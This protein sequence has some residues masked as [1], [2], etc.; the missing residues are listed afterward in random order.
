PGLGGRIGSRAPM[1]LMSGSGCSRRVHLWNGTQGFQSGNVLLACPWQRRPQPVILPD[2]SSLKPGGSMP[3][4]SNSLTSSQNSRTDVQQAL[5]TMFAN[6]ATALHPDYAA[7]I[8][9]LSDA[10]ALQAALARLDTEL[11]T[12]ANEQLRDNHGIN[13]PPSKAKLIKHLN[14]N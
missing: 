9:L 10:T 14:N 1:L 3:L 2:G 8:C 12:A 6:K 13:Q 4:D 7:A 11:V 5:N